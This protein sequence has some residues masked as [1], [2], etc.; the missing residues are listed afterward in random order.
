MVFYDIKKQ[1]RQKGNGYDFQVR[2]S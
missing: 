2:G 1:M